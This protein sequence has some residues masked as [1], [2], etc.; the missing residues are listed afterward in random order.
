MSDLPAPLTPP[1]CDLR[2]YP[3]LPVD[4]TRLFGSNFHATAKDS[5]WRAGMTLWMKSFHQ[6]PAAS[7]PEDD[8]ELTMLADLGR[9]VKTWRKLKA[10]ALQG[11]FK[12]SDGR[13]Y[14]KVVAEK[15]LIAW[16]DKLGQRKSSAAGNATRWNI[17]FDP[18]EFERALNQ[19]A[20]LLMTINPGAALLKKKV[21]KGYGQ[22]SQNSTAGEALGSRPDTTG[23]PVGIAAGSPTG[24]TTGSPG[25]IAR[26]VKRKVQVQPKGK[27]LLYHGRED[28]SGGG[29]THV[30]EEGLTDD[31]GDDRYPDMDE[32]PMDGDGEFQEAGSDNDPFPAS[33]PEPT[34][35]A[36]A[37]AR[38]KPDDGWPKDFFQQWYRIYPRHIGPR[39]AENA[40]VRLRKSGSV[41]WPSL[42]SATERYADQIRRHP[43]DDPKFIPHPSTW[44]NKGRWADEPD[45]QL[46]HFNPNSGNQ[47]NGSSSI[48]A[49][50]DRFR[51]R[52]GRSNG[53][54]EAFDELERENRTE[55]H[56]VPGERGLL[57]E[58]PGRDG[59][60]DHDGE[61]H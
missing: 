3:S 37:T 53:L 56:R 19:A 24:T 51:N 55:D 1:D 31:D 22:Q 23:N 49:A 18:A 47:G 5:E 57:L 20:N 33:R 44:L 6:V 16:I 29:S 61:F 15:A 26:E 7:L 35:A 42:L 17:V 50:V 25:G 9:D 12:C 38:P 46:S 43:P 36:K 54:N 27:N 10:K 13:L 48:S 4:I 14:H 32:I 21:L 45:P 28:L 59:H 41:T 11:W 8:A 2:D 30:R 39:D 34:P 40:L 58:G 60:G 52:Y